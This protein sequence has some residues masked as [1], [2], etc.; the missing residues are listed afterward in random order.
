M[1]RAVRRRRLHA[2]FLVWLKFSDALL[3]YRVGKMRRGLST[4]QSQ[5]VLSL[6]RR[7]TCHIAHTYFI[8]HSYYRGFLKLVR[9]NRILYC[10]LRRHF[11]SLNE[12]NDI[13]HPAVD[14]SIVN[15]PS[16]ASPPRP[17][18]PPARTR[19]STVVPPPPPPRLLNITK[20]VKLHSIDVD[21]GVSIFNAS[22]DI[23]TGKSSDE[24][25]P[26]RPLPPPPPPPRVPEAGAG[27]SVVSEMQ[28]FFEQRELIRTESHSP[29]RK[30]ITAALGNTQARHI[31]E[32]RDSQDEVTSPLKTRKGSLLCQLFGS[33]DLGTPAPTKP[34]GE[35]LLTVRDLSEYFESHL[36]RCDD[37]LTHPS[38]I[39]RS[40]TM[41]DIEANSD[42]E[43]L[44]S[45]ELS[46]W[47]STP[48]LSG[49]SGDFIQETKPF[50][51]ASLAG[52]R[53][54]SVSFYTKDPAPLLGV[55][56]DSLGGNSFCSFDTV[57][58]C[59]EV[60]R[61]AEEKS[62]SHQLFRSDTMYGYL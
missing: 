19:Q 42:P 9:H 13:E 6:A 26:N 3:L 25:M 33:T 2:L 17:P 31:C 34:S 53:R 8:I 11:G 16:P 62:G 40:Q 1:Y 52:R 61:D 41:P 43:L 23:G 59:D 45:F 29:T 20:E 10:R 57:A 60:S 30:S 48:E 39:L 56:D 15:D 49:H 58:E 55:R 32:I 47:N 51:R 54:H 5:T 28:K 12:S 21:V 36:F 44:K 22:E 24:N 14:V 4:L 37:S 35:Q 46:R 7:E 27:A 50:R 38:T 18:P